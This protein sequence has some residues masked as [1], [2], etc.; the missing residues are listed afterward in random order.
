MVRESKQQA[1]FG[2][3]LPRGRQFEM[4]VHRVPTVDNPGTVEV[5]TSKGQYLRFTVNAGGP[6]PILTFTGTNNEKE[7]KDFP[8]HPQASYQWDHL[9]DP[10]QVQ[11]LDL[12]V[13]DFSFFSNQSYRYRV[14]VY[15][16]AGKPLKTVLDIQFTGD[17]TDT[18]PESFNV[19]IG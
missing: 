2:R 4:A 3:L 6:I 14:E 13:I 5:N 17:S 18:A 11:Q 15:E 7:A 16:D 12:L 19:I 8:G 10:S 9:K 1:K